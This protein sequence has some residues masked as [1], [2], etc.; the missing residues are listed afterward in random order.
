MK[1]MTLL[2]VLGVMIVPVAGTLKAQAQDSS[3]LASGGTSPIT[4][5]G[6]LGSYGELYSI[7][8]RS[9][10]RPSATGRLFFRPTLNLYD[11]MSIDFD[12][13]LS[14][15]G[16]QA[17]QDINQFGINPVWGWGRAHLGDFSDAYS[18]YTL[19]GIRVRGAGFF[20]NPGLFRLGAFGGVTKRAVYG[21]GGNESYE[22]YLYGGRIGIGSTEGGFLDLLF[23]RARDRVSSMT[24]STVTATV[25]S[26]DTT[27]SS[28]QSYEVTPQENM[29][30]G[31][32]SHGTAFDR[33]VIWNVE[34]TGSIFTRDM[35]E[36]ADK[37]L[38]LPDW[39]TDIYRANV[40]SCLGLAVRSD[41]SFTFGMMN[42]RTG[43]RY[44]GP[45]YYSLGVGSLPNDIQEFSLAP[46]FRMGRW[47]VSVNAVRQNDNL[48]GQKENTLVRYQYCGNISVL[49][50]SRWFMSILGNYLT[51]ANNASNDTT[52]IEYGSLMLGTTQSYAFP[53][54]SFF[55][56]VNLSYIFQHSADSSPLRSDEKFTSHSANAGVTIPIAENIAFSPGAGFVVTKIPTH[57]AQ[58]TQS[59]TMSAQHRTL[60]NTLISV[61]SCVMSKSPSIA[62]Y[63]TTLSST[64]RLTST[65]S[66]GVSVSMMNYRIDSIYGGDF[67]EYF[68]SVSISQR[69]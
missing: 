33:H 46:S 6:E 7:D 56:S 57:S 26:T 10:R 25:D 54:H 29:V 53:E 28:V 42:M 60:D 24:S 49:P 36:D 59:Y 44:V 40:T 17:T 18:Q 67:N 3:T 51:M 63:R 39:V 58:A 1:A 43:Y 50:T 68:G 27:T 34:A 31:L 64:Y 8:G 65:A 15:E 32:M 30:V 11:A 48:V 61:L 12:F 5:S 16:S 35:R 2:F 47:S 14:T 38:K 9:A 4:L 45:G 37:P 13:L 20:I 52:R 55:Q 69:F 21:S 41:L 22:R 62:S 19:N 23:L 66:I